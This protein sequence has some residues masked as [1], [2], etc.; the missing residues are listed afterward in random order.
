[1][2]DISVPVMPGALD[3]PPL[4]QGQRVIYT[5]TA[6]SKTFK[7][8]MRSTSWW[9]PFLLS[10]I[11]TYA[12]FGAVG[13]KV[14]W[15][16]VAE[17]SI[18]QNPKQSEQFDKLTPDQRATQLKIAGMVTEGIFAV[19]PIISLISV[20]IIAGVLMATINFGFAGKASFWQVFAVVWYGGL[21]GLLKVV[22]GV[23]ALFAGMAPESFNSQNFSGTNIGY[24]LSPDTAKPLLRLA[25]SLDAVTIWTLVLYAI[26]ISIVAG[27]KRSSGFVAVF[28]WWILIVLGGVGLAAIF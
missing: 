28:A 21:P 15:Q 22:M 9:L 13:A 26:G 25:T 4:T 14:G 7:D 3:T 12:L 6:P 23:A 16:Q 5:F 24:Y 10:V 20:A 2:S 27:V 17:N 18:K 19:F 8:I 1:M 11:F